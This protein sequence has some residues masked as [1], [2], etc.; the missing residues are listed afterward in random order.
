MKKYL[1]TNDE[2]QVVINDR[3]EILIVDERTS[4]SD[5]VII[6]GK[7]CRVQ[8]VWLMTNAGTDPVKRLIQVG[9]NSRL[10]AWQLYNSVS[11]ANLVIENHLGERVAFDNKVLF[12]QAGEAKLSIKDDYCFNQLGAYGR[13]DIQGFATNQARIEYFSD[14]QIKPE[15]QKT[16]SRIDMKLHLLSPE[17]RGS[18][19]PGLQIDANDVKAGHSAI[20]FKLAPE[21][22]F[23]LASRGLDLERIKELVMQSAVKHFVTGLLDEELKNKII[24]TLSSRPAGEIA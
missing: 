19:L 17:A 15:A 14:L 8:Y 1:V 18:L 5:L 6:I 12:Y 16:D 3:E 21:D 4:A 11:G 20:T 24:T 7:H 22:L 23:Y 13:F 9:D 2:R 10:E